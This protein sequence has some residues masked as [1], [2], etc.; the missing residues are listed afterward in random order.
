MK[1]VSG[2]NET[3]NEVVTSIVI[4]EQQRQ[5]F[6]ELGVGVNWPLN[7]LA[8]QA[9]L[10][11]VEV[12]EAM[13]KGALWLEKRKTEKKSN[14]RGTAID[15]WQTAGSKQSNQSFNK[16][17][18]IRRIRARLC[19]GD[20]LTLYFNRQVLS[21][22]CL[23]PC[24]ID[25][26]GDY[27]VWDKPA[28]MRCQGSKWGDHTTLSRWFEINSNPS[29]E[30]FTV[31]RLDRMATGLV[32]LAHSKSVAAFLSSKFEKREIAKRYQVIVHGDFKESLPLRIDQAIT[33]KSAVTII[34][35]AENAQKLI[36][37]N[38]GI[39]LANQQ[40]SFENSQNT[41]TLLTLSIETG[42][43]HQIRRHLADLNYPV[44]GDRMYVNAQ[45]YSSGADI[46]LQLRAVEIGLVDKE[47]NLPLNWK[48]LK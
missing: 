23:T 4:S 44:V 27:S 39:A 30:A 16:P 31:H 3:I 15:I 9:G 19:E 8:E 34:E 5:H 48:V 41:Y 17:R 46:D 37:V 2:S 28:T 42:R 43:K 12:K 20:R 45:K 7:L 40:S 32:L 13:N 10:T 33:G 36:N 1:I 25:D 38:P 21:S 18:R 24:L 47:S 14:A 29:R 11:R 35:K 26:R 6:E 22:K